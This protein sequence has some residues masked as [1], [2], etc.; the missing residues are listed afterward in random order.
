MTKF[1]KTSDAIAELRKE[2]PSTNV[3]ELKSWLQYLKC[4]VDYV[5][6]RKPNS[7]KARYEWNVEAI[8]KLWRLP[9]EQRLPKK[10]R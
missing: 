4:G 2:F 6:K 3:K 8:A 5:D 9:P 7:R 10:V 1:F